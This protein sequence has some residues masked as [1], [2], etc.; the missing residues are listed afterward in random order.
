MQNLNYSLAKES[1][2]PFHAYLLLSDSSKYV[3][4]Q[5][6]QFASKIN[7]SENYEDNHPDVRLITSE[8]INTIGIEDVRDVLNKD[9]LSPISGKYKVIIFPPYKSLTEEASNALLK[10]LEEPSESSIFILTSTGSFWSHAKDDANRGIINTIKSRCRTVFVES[11][12]VTTYD[13]TFDDFSNFIDIR[14]FKSI[15]NK[16]KVTNLLE[17]LEQ[18]TSTNS[19]SGKNMFRFQSLLKDVKNIQLEFEEATATFGNKL[20]TRS[21]EYLVRALLTSEDIDKFNYRYC[22]LIQNATEE[23]QQ[24]MRD[25]IV[26]NNLSVELAEL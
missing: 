20:T 19:T 7:L 21:L 1:K 10:T 17:N 16:D 6:I 12:T 3:L 5:A 8:N 26:L 24:G 22:E 9:N 14:D 23:I 13:F 11:E 4:E 2:S 15:V 25:S 18:L